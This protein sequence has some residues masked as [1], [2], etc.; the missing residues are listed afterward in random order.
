MQKY[1]DLL[2][3]VYASLPEKKSSGERF[4]IPVIDAFLEGNK[5]MVRNFP[6]ICEKIRRP[7]D[8]VAKYLSKALAVPSA[9]EGSRLL[10]HAKINSRLINEKFTLYCQ[11]HVVCHECKKPDTYL[12][13]HGRGPKTLVCEACGA[14]S[15]VIG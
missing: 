11:T 15:P 1:E 4:E 5:T 2:E 9:V 3:S 6:E 10:L 13:S 12:E 7:P 8:E 14:R